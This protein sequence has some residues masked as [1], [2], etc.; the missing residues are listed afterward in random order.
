MI[1]K[2]PKVVSVAAEGFTISIIHLVHRI[3]KM[4]RPAFSSAVRQLSRPRSSHTSPLPAPSFSASFCHASY[5]APVVASTPKQTP[6]V[7]DSIR[8]VPWSCLKATQ[9]RSPFSSSATKPAAQVTQNPRSGEDG[10]TLMVDISA[11]A[12]KVRWTELLCFCDKLFSVRWVGL[13]A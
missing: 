11:R 1:I 6:R 2:P 8:T 10:N 9:H 3:P 7:R 5:R 13:L 12:A 4:S